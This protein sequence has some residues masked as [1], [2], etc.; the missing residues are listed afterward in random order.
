MELIKI[1][2]IGLQSPQRILKL[3]LDLVG[4]EKI[5]PFEVR[6][7]FVTELGSNNPLLAPALDGMADQLLR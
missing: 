6:L 4:L 7:E 5:F 3:L 1:D 2:V